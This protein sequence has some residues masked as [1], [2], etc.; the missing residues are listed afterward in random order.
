MTSS[1]NA[2]NLFIFSGILQILSELYLD[3]GTKFWMK[4]YSINRYPYATLPA[5]DL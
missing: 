1:C 3:Q 4:G 2:F 5:F